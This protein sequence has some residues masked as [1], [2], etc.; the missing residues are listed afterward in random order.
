M[1]KKYLEMTLEEK[2]KFLG[3]MKSDCEYY[4]GEGMKQVSALWGKSVDNH[5]K[6]MKELFFSI[7]GEK[8][9]EWLTYQDILDFSEKMDHRPVITAETL[10]LS[11]ARFITL[12]GTPANRKLRQRDEVFFTIEKRTYREKE[13]N[14]AFHYGPKEYGYV[15]VSP[16]MRKIFDT[17][18]KDRRD[19]RSISFIEWDDSWNAVFEDGIYIS[20][21]MCRMER[22]EFAEWYRTI[23]PVE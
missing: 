12:S 10:G 11:G 9:P 2:Y 5:L 15:K 8:R 7:P 22:S 6:Y 1:E 4:L 3:R 20:S 13:G 16:E 14:R 17:L 19:N 18:F 23:K 21:R